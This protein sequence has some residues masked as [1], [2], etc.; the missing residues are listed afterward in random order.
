MSS[1]LLTPSGRAFDGGGNTRNISS[2]PLAPCIMY[3]PDNEP[4]PEQGQ[5][6]PPGTMAVTV[7]KCHQIDCHTLNFASNIAP[8]MQLAWIDPGKPNSVKCCHFPPNASPKIAKWLLMVD[9]NAIKSI[10]TRSISHRILRRGCI[11]LGLT[12]GNLLI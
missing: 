9:T 4:F 3:W 1:P 6:K 10:A 8:G 12:Q 7:D 2:D 5:I 11:W